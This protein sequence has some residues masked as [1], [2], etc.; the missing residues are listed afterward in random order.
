MYI[1][2][3]A[4]LCRLI[5]ILTLTMARAQSIP[6]SGFILGSLTSVWR[7][8]TQQK[9][10]SLAFAVHHCL[11]P[12]GLEQLNSNV[13]DVIRM[14][15]LC[16][17]ENKS[18]ELTVLLFLPLAPLMCGYVSTLLCGQMRLR[19]SVSSC[20]VGINGPVLEPTISVQI[21]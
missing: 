19:Q 16:G 1:Y 11:F 13:F 3:L 18:Q 5:G 10:L 17:W 14:C 20:C 7:L 2:G 6:G 21:C 8:T 15:A 9:F 12:S 4:S